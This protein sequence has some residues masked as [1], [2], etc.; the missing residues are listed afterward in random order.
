MVNGN[1]NGWVRE[2]FHKVSLVVC[3]RRMTVLIGSFASM[4]GSWRLPATLQGTFESLFTST[5]PV[6]V[7]TVRVTELC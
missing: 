2:Y 3:Y 4:D 7:A 6:S 5:L 1:G